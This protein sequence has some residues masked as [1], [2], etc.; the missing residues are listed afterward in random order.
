MKAGIAD[1]LKLCEHFAEG[2][3]VCV[4]LGDNIIE[5]DITPYVQRFAAQTSGA[6]LL[7]KEVEDPERFGVP[8]LAGSRIVRIDEKPKVPKSKYAVTGIY[9]YDGRVFDYCRDLKPSARGELEIHRRQQRL[10]CGRRSALRHSR[11]LVDGRGSVRKLVFATQLI[12]KQRANEAR[13]LKNVLTFVSPLAREEPFELR[14]VRLR[15]VVGDDAAAGL[16]RLGVVLDFIV[17][18]C[19]G[20]R[21]CPTANPRRSRAARRRCRARRCR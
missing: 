17:G 11:G 9:M 14:H 10:R 12:A 19:R 21:A 7:L 1:A 4:I 13:T 18:N 20:R 2:E 16:E 15:A 3:P 5:D 8:E 6:R